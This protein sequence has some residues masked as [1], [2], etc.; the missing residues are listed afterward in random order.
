MFGSAKVRRVQRIR[1]RIEKLIRLIEELQ[2][3]LH[4]R[5]LGDP[6]RERFEREATRMLQ[7]YVRVQPALM[8]A[9]QAS[10]VR[11]PA[12]PEALARK[13]CEAP[14]TPQPDSPYQEHHLKR[15]AKRRLLEQ[16]QARVREGAPAPTRQ[17][18]QR[19]DRSL[20]RSS[21]PTSGTTGAA[22]PPPG[23][24]PA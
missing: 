12:M 15:S 9:W 6:E 20:G 11:V 16:A 14:T 22:T 18:I 23:S 2:I 24:P 17:E 7:A 13:S 19:L 1:R 5:P 21:G 4:E 3:V 8:R 10:R